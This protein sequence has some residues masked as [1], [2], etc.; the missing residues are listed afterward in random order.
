VFCSILNN[1]VVKYPI[2]IDIRKIVINSFKQIGSAR[3]QDKRRKQKD[4]NQQSTE[5]IFNEF[6]VVFL[7]LNNSITKKKIKIKFFQLLI[8]SSLKKNQ[9]KPLRI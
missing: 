2:V 5:L 4:N 9:Q 7:Y 6:I 3:K 8:I 1:I